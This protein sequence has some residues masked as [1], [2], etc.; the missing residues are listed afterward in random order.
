MNNG[1]VIVIIYSSLSLAGACD[2]ATP[3][4]CF[5]IAG[6]AIH[7]PTLKGDVIEAI[8]QSLCIGAHV[9]AMQIRFL[10]F[11]IASRALLIFA[12]NCQCKP[13]DHQYDTRTLEIPSLT[14]E[15]LQFV[16]EA[17]SW[18]D[19]Q[20]NCMK[21]GGLLVQILTPEKFNFTKGLHRKSTRYTNS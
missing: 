7:F 4:M 3:G 1:I 6:D 16:N 15:C 2:L 17:I 21:S 12:A 10:L 11:L 13:N 19:A 20:G 9:F 18:L 5:V 14:G 8:T